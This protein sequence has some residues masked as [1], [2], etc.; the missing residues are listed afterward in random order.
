MSNKIVFTE[1]FLSAF[2]VLNETIDSMLDS[3]NFFDFRIWPIFNIADICIVL[4][5]GMIIY[6]MLCAEKKLKGENNE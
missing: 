4:G 5:V 3:F 2:N 6:A 1:S